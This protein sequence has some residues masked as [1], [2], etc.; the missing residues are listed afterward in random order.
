MGLINWLFRKL[1]W[2]LAQQQHLR[3]GQQGVAEQD[4]HQTNNWE[5]S[6]L[7]LRISI[8]MASTNSAIIELLF[9]KGRAI[10]DRIEAEINLTS[11]STV[12]QLKE[13]RKWVERQE[14]MKKFFTHIQELR[15]T[16]ATAEQRSEEHRANSH[17][18][19]QRQEESSQEAHV[20]AERHTSHEEGHKHSKAFIAE[21]GL[22]EPEEKEF[23][24][25]TKVRR[26]NSK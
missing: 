2:V 11:D 21:D 24:A 3:K 14:R 8:R 18:E 12:E 5:F 7:N 16:P 23:L 9:N 25:A 22:L 13:R 10:M 6:R 20:A 19:R 26:V 4:S 17:E 15:A 1:G